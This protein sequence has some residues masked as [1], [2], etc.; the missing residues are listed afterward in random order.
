MR[1][2]HD[3][4]TQTLVLSHTIAVSRKV[5]RAQGFGGIGSNLAAH[6]AA[7]TLRRPRCFSRTRPRSRT[8]HD[9][10]ASQPSWGT[11]DGTASVTRLRYRSWDLRCQ[12]LT[13]DCN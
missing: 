6:Q 7:E 11:C 10:S 12:A 3:S 1:L 8:S 9:G 13:V 2:D 5:R 4:A